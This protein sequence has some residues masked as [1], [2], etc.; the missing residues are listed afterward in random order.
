MKPEFSRHILETFSM[1]KFHENPFS[2]SRVPCGRKVSHDEANFLFFEYFMN[3]LKN[4][5]TTE[6]TRSDH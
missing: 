6:G 3:T 1:I 5:Q 2:G 4:V